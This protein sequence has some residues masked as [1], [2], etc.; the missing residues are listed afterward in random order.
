MNDNEFNT[1]KT[2]LDKVNYVF[3]HDENLDEIL[4]EELISLKELVILIQS[5]YLKFK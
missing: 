1:L 3:T 5:V 2:W 4:N